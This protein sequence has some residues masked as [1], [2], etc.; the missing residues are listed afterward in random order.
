MFCRV[1]GQASLD[2]NSEVHVPLCTSD[3]RSRARGIQTLRLSAR[4][5]LSLG[6]GRRH[7]R[8][9]KQTH[10]YIVY[11]IVCAYT[12]IYIYIY[13]YRRRFMGRGDGNGGTGNRNG[14]KATLRP[15]KAF[16][17]RFQ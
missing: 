9:A 8:I 3:S 14:I 4:K 17:V 10:V 6:S 15:S 16:L 7:G 12:Y 5:S 1:G 2:S 13:T 11:T